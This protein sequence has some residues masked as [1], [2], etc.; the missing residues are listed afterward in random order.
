MG[1]DA[2]TLKDFEDTIRQEIPD[3]RVRFKDQSKLHKFLAFLASPFNPDYM[4]RFTTTMGDTVWF[5]SEA[6]YIE[7]PH[8]SLVILAHEYVHLWDQKQGRL[9]F[10]LS[11][12]FPQVLGVLPLLVFAVLSGAWAWLVLLPLIGYLLACLTAKVSKVLFAAVLGVALLGTFGLAWWLVGW[13]ICLLLAGLAFFAPWPA[14]WRVK[15]EERGY[16]MNLAISIWRGFPINESYRES[17]IEHF[18]SGEYFFMSWSR[19][20]VEGWV[21]RTRSDVQREVQQGLL[22]YRHVYDFLYARRLLA[23]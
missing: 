21:D 13:K 10:K 12:M 3:F 4:T 7:D 23:R 19:R 8:R 16:A 1:L 18:C 14:P 17:L 22:P 2:S 15:L 6:Y 11:Y 5:P 20:S 9:R